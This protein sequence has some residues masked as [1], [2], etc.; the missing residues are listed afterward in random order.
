MTSRQ[1]KPT[2]E[3]IVPKDQKK[4]G[5]NPQKNIGQLECV[6]AKTSKEAAK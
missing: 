2:R 1:K 4:R 6:N 3:Y 5:D